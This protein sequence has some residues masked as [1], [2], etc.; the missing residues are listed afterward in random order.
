MKI[1]CEVD[2]PVTRSYP[3]GDD[4]MPIILGLI[5][6]RELDGLPNPAGELSTSD[7]NMSHTSDDV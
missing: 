2:R 1:P 7:M 4:V 3:E 6:I 5:V